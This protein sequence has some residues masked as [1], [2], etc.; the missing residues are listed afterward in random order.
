MSLMSAPFGSG[1]PPKIAFAISLGALLRDASDG[2]VVLIAGRGNTNRCPS[3]VKK[4]N[5]LS[6]PCQ[7]DGVPSPNRG[8]TTGPPKD[9]PKLLNRS[10]GLNAS[11]KSRASNLS[12][13]TYSNREP[14]YL[15]SP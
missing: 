9:P 12:L 10:G 5:V 14:W 8:K 1:N 4:K 7:R 13:R 3:Y 2:T 11:K 6:F 15:F